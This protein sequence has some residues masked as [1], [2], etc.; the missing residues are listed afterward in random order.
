M[1]KILLI[2][3]L[4]IGMV[5]TAQKESLGIIERTTEQ[6]LYVVDTIT[7]ETKY[8]CYYD[9]VTYESGNDVYYHCQGDTDIIL[10]NAS[11]PSGIET[12]VY[13]YTEN[14]ERKVKLHKLADNL[15]YREP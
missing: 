2:A 8:T 11:S 12:L 13:L 10:L 7:I 9:S 15:W 4:L 1:K 5:G 6:V 14:G 3:M